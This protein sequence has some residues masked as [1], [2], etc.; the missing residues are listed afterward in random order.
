MRRY[1]SVKSRP[2]STVESEK[3][4]VGDGDDDD[5]RSTIGPSSSATRVP[6]S[7]L[8]PVTLKVKRFDYYYSKWSRKWKYTPTSSTA[9]PELRA[10]PAAADPGK[11]DP[12]AQFCFVVVRTIPQ[13]ED[14]EITY[15]V[16]VK[17]PYLL[18]ACKEVIQE[19]KGVSWNAIPL[20]VW[21]RLPRR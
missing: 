20:E 9:L 7:P 1:L 10:G 4:L 14:S 11:E 8:P 21:F 18:S 2:Q 3:N 6:E 19:V 13:A 12:W 16:V 17:S 5:E 15:K